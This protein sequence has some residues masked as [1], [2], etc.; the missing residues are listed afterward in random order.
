MLINKET[1]QVVIHIPKTAGTSLTKMLGQCDGWKAVNNYPEV[2]VTVNQINKYVN[3]EEYVYYTFVRNPYT[4]FESMYNFIVMRKLLFDYTPVDLA[5][6]IFT[7]KE[8]SF[9]YNTMVSFCRKKDLVDFGRVEN[10]YSDAT[11]MFKN[12]MKNEFQNVSLKNKKSL[13]EIYPNLRDMVARLYYEDFVEFGYDIQ[14]FIYKP[15]PATLTEDNFLKVYTYE[16]LINLL[17]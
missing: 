2:H 11:R 14:P 6:N 10:F 7:G 1:K 9:F 12:E 15:V 4:R 17:K 8:T 3:D 13:Y 16:Q 5:I